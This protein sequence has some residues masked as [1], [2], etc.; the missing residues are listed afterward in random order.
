MF[1]C[2]VRLK[3]QCQKLLCT[4]HI[5]SYW[6]T[7]WLLCSWCPKHTNSW[8]FLIMERG[9]MDIVRSLIIL[10]MRPSANINSNW[11]NLL[12]I[13]SYCTKT[14]NNFWCLGECWISWVYKTNLVHLCWDM[15]W[16][17]TVF[18]VH[19]GMLGYVEVGRACVLAC[20]DILGYV[21]LW[22]GMFE[23]LWVCFVMFMFIWVHIFL[24]VVACFQGN[25]LFLFQLFLLSSL[26]WNKTYKICDFNIVYWIPFY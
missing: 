13:G 25:E 6:A 15:L 12:L 17:M 20:W 7:F 10:C 8:T 5:S 9:V 16:H 23:Y 26:C 2:R 19:F 24:V 4:A 22:F 11:K 18:W 21:L 14:I 3:I 1:F